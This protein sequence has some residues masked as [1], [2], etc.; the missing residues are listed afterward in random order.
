MSTSARSGLAD[1]VWL[2]LSRIV[3]DNKDTWRRDLVTLAAIVAKI[4]AAQD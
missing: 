1:K 4:A 3:L 2:D